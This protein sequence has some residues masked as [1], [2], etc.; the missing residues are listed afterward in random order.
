MNAVVSTQNQANVPEALKYMHLALSRLGL[1]IQADDYKKFNKQLASKITACNHLRAA[2]DLKDIVSAQKASS[3][4]IHLIASGFAQSSTS[5]SSVLSNLAFEKIQLLLPTLPS[6]VQEHFSNQEQPPPMSI[7]DIVHGVCQTHISLMEMTNS[8][9]DT[10]VRCSTYLALRFDSSDK[11]I[12]QFL[13]KLW[14]TIDVHYSSKVDFEKE[15]S[16]TTTQSMPHHG[17]TD[18][19]VPYHGEIPSNLNRVLLET[20]FRGSTIL[21]QLGPYRPLKPANLPSKLV[22]HFKGGIHP[23]LA[24]PI[25]DDTLYA[26]AKKNVETALK[27]LSSYPTWADNF[28]PKKT[29]YARKTSAAQNVSL[30]KHKS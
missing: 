8:T 4:Y 30:L 14:P 7:S 21:N 11:A 5:D 12:A 17:H 25:S 23:F 15:I 2:N 20:Y 27:L 13:T 24:N 16:R 26:S 9:C 3:L 22:E 6:V 18:Q 10:F 19:P 28:S 29:S 1:S